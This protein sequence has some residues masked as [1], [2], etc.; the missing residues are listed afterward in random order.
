VPPMPTPGS[1]KKSLM[2]TFSRVS[3]I[4]RIASV[5]RHG[6]TAL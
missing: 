2:V 4:S 1:S 6:R 5:Y 3:R